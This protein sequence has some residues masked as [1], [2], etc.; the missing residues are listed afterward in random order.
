MNEE[1]LKMYLTILNDENPS[2]VKE[3]AKANIIKLFEKQQIENRLK[4]DEINNLYKFISIREERIDELAEIN[5]KY[6]DLYISKDKIREKIE[7]YKKKCEECNFQNTGVCK[8]FKAHYNC[9]IQSVLEL[10]KEL[11][12]E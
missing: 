11:I 9:S 3:N 10:L 8:E 4:E 5:E 2:Y 1:K 7:E 12:G 6:N